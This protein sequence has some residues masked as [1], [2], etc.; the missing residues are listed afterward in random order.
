[1]TTI[2]GVRA[3]KANFNDSLYY[4]T[5][6][7]SKKRNALRTDFN[8]YADDND[9]TEQDIVSAYNAANNTL[10][11]LQQ[12]MY[13]IIKG[14]RDLGI[15][16]AT[17]YEMITEKGTMSKSE[18][19]MISEGSFMPFNVTD[20]LIERIL[21]DRLIRNEPGPVRDLPVN[22]L[23]DAYENV[24]GKSLIGAS[25]PKESPTGVFDQK[26]EKP[27]FAPKLMQSQPVD[28]RPVTINT[29]APKLISP[30]TTS[31]SLLGGNIVDQAKNLEILRRRTQ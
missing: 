26:N 13:R 16:D 17:I 22:Q 23:L 14:A 9:L 6:E 21:R 8:S 15:D 28:T 12:D 30:Q 24:L 4:K 5:N 27:T 7:Y 10:Y 29:F 18:F 1:M 2:T 19:Q 25:D 20:D 31:P 11:K 3:L